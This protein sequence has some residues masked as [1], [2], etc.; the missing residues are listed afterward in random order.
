MSHHVDL[1]FFTESFTLVLIIDNG[2]CRSEWIA[3]DISVT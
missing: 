2:N 1:H 3:V